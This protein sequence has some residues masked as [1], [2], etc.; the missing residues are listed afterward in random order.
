MD[1]KAIETVV[2]KL[3]EKIGLASDQLGEVA[4]I[5]VQQYQLSAVV[6]TVIAGLFMLVGLFIMGKMIVT[7]H[8]MANMDEC[9][10]ESE[11]LAPS[12]LA[13]VGFV[14]AI[15]GAIGFFE[16]LH[17]ALAPIASMLSLG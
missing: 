2:D 14:F 3:A 6:Y 16:C 8:A 12:L 10:D 4:N 15:G 9:L 5:T 7:F 1:P 17:G 13:F 11:W